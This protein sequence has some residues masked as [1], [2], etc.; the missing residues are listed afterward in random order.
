MYQELKAIAI[1]HIGAIKKDKE[2]LSSITHQLNELTN[3]NNQM[4]EK[5]HLLSE[6]LE[7]MKVC[8]TKLSEGHINH[9]NDLVNSML[10]QVFDDKNYEIEFKLDDNKNGK[11]LNILLKDE[12]SPGEI[13]VTDIHDNGGG[14]QT[15]IGF[16]LQIYFIIYFNQEHI[17]FLDEQLSALSSNYISNLIKFMDELV[18]KYNFVFVSVI[19][20]QRFIDS[21]TDQPD[22]P[23]RLYNVEDGQ[24]SYTR[25]YN[26]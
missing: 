24:I 21:I 23:I 20:D 2:Q 26:M 14:L 10:K 22:L 4:K 15:I 9:L 17:I 16:I 6:S 1:E 11:I 13:V 18:K 3:T 19:H 12:I 7:V 5:L 25:E 8:I